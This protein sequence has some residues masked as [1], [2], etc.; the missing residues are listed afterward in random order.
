MNKAIVLTVLLGVCAC[1]K[2]IQVPTEAEF[3]A[4]PKM[5]ADW[6]QKCTKGE[7]SNLRAEE[8]SRMCGSAQSAASV[9]ANKNLAKKHDQLFNQ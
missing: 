8:H 7:Y 6:M 1:T 4:N 3:E 5:L 2:P 9:L